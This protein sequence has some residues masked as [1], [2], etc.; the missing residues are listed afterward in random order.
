M[1]IL[2]RERVNFQ[3]IGNEVTCRQKVGLKLQKPSISLKK[4]NFD[5]LMG[6]KDT[7]M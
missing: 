6:E 3:W 7:K 4:K 1:T 5:S 2:F